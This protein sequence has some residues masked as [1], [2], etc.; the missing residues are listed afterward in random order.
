MIW[1]ALKKIPLSSHHNTLH[2]LE[3]LI[4]HESLFISIPIWADIL[5]AQPGASLSHLLEALSQHRAHDWNRSMWCLCRILALDT[6]IPHLLPAID[7]ALVALSSSPS[8]SQKGLA[9][10]RN[11]HFLTSLTSPKFSIHNGP[12]L[13]FEL[14]VTSVHTMRARTYLVLVRDSVAFSATFPVWHVLSLD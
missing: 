8:Y 4:F 10:S 13:T 1:C 9:N 12:M 2:S 5:L 7:N 3:T 14:L 6:T 11:N